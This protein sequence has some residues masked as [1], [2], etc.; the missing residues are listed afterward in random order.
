MI[1]VSFKPCRDVTLVAHVGKSG[2]VRAKRKATTK[3]LKNK[4][5]ENWELKRKAR[6]EATRQRRIAIKEYLRKKSEDLKMRPRE[7]FNTF[8]SF[9][10]KKDHTYNT[11]IH[12]N[13]NGSIVR[14]QR[15][16]AEIL[17]DYFST[18][19]EGIGGKNALNTIPVFRK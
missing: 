5:K 3:Y 10:N 1:F 8:R 4:T 12:L 7:F 18:I 9:L 19:A 13:D 15:E 2:N 14:N 16:V 6:N 11:E 17:A